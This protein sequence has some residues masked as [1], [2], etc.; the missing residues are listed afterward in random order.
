MNFTN[1]AASD[2]LASST[3]C[4]SASLSIGAHRL[5]CRWMHRRRMR[6]TRGSAVASSTGSTATGTP[7]RHPHHAL[8]FSSRSLVSSL[9][10][11]TPNSGMISFSSLSSS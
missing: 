8:V 7:T 9:S 4:C 1:A 5:K 10:V 6:G 11:F 3:R 2:F